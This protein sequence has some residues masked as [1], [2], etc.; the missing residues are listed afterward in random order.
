MERS[1]MEVNM[2]KKLVEFLKRLF[3]PKPKPEPEDV[4]QDAVWIY[5]INILAWPKTVTLKNVSA[6]LAG[7][8][9]GNMVH[10]EYDVMQN[11]P[12]WNNNE[13]NVNANCWIV[14]TFDGKRYVSTFDYLRRGQF[15]KEF[16]YIPFQ[17]T[18]VWI[19]SPKESGK[20]IEVWR[21]KQGE[22]VGFMVSG[23]ARDGRRTV[24]ERS[25]VVFVDW[26]LNIWG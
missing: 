15:D 7:N 13:Y 20:L 16:G 26:P 10:M 14:F 4:L 3:K 23:I 25:N 8:A 18:G 2:W 22:K 6:R 24:N 17:N 5:G 9:M 1:G 19:D 12:P 11:W 21:P